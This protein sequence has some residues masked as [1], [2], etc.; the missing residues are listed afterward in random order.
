M[1]DMFGDERLPVRFW[2]KVRRSEAGCWEWQASLTAGGYGQ[3]YPTK[4]MPRRAHR[5]AYEALVAAV[6]AGLVLDHLCRNRVC[7][8]PA[9]LEPVTQWENTLRGDSPIAAHAAVTHCPAGHPYSGDNLR[10]RRS[11]RRAC[12]ACGIEHNRQWR[13]RKRAEEAS[14]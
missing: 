3:Y 14:K 1:S 5:V 6:P 8:N 10:I 9:H 11:G 12:R 7:C 2:A 4:R 13:A